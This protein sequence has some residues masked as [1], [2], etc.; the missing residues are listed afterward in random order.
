ML[1]KGYCFL[2]VFINY[3]ALLVEDAGDP[4]GVGE[5]FDEFLGHVAVGAKGAGDH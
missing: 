4:L 3:G 1:I 2:E 5:L